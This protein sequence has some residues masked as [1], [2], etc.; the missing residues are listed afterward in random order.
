M[1]GSFANYLEAKLM[2]HWLKVSAMTPA[3]H[4]YVGLSTANPGEAGAG[5]A[6]P[7][8]NAYARVQADSWSANSGGESHN[9]GAITFPKATG[10]WGTCTHFGIFDASTGGN[11]C[12][13]GDLTVVKTITSGDTPSYAIG[14]LSITLD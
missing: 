14:D 4:L 9:S 10:N 12:A 13:Y 5:L 8:G 3:T 7:S 2:D 1:A 11:L 6:E